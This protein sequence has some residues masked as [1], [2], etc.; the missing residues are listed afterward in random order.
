[1]VGQ[2]NNSQAVLRDDLRE[3]LTRVIGAGRW[4][5]EESAI[6][7]DA[8]KTK[9]Y[10]QLVELVE[11]GYLEEERSKDG[12]YCIPTEKARGYFQANVNAVGK[13][14][15]AIRKPVEFSGISDAR[16]FIMKRCGHDQDVQRVLYYILDLLEPSQRVSSSAKSDSQKKES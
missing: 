13:V 5:Y 1:M 12:I 3:M 10:F 14:M 7:P 2:I 9:T 16:A 11:G 4:K 8:P 15:S 6:D